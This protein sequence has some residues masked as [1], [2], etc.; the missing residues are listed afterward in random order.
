MMENKQALNLYMDTADLCM[1]TVSTMHNEFFKRCDYDWWRKVQPGDIVVDI[2]ACVGMFTAHALDRGASK[3]YSLE[4]NKKF[5]K[6]IINNMYDYIVN[7]DEIRFIPVDYAIGS[8]PS[9]TNFVFHTNEFKTMSFKEF[10]DRF[11]IEKIDYLKLDCEGGEYD[12]LSKE[13]LSWIKD[14][15]KHIAVECH[16]RAS[17]NGIEDFIKFRDEFLAPFLSTNKVRYMNPY[18]SKCIYNDLEINRMGEIMM[19]ILNE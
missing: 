16:L 2:G 12:V 17:E 19:Y 18:I 8:K 10:I 9:H 1:A 11:K 14:N 13:N 6:T 15:V 7:E 3:V 5:M 4:P